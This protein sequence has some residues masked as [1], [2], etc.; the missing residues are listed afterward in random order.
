MGFVL[1]ALTRSANGRKP[2]PTGSNEKS[3]SEWGIAW[4]FI[5][6][7]L[8]HTAEVKADPQWAVLRIAEVKNCLVM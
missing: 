3:K 5:T 1:D 6:A 4:L 8:T 7:T 2:R